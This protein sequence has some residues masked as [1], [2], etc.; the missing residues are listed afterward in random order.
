MTIHS[1]VFFDVIILHIWDEEHEDDDYYKA[2]KS[3]YIQVLFYEISS[4]YRAKHSQLGMGTIIVSDGADHFCK[5]KMEDV[6]GMIN[7]VKQA[8]MMIPYAN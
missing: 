3:D 6:V 7:M 5:M 2:K 4:V 8:E 1:G